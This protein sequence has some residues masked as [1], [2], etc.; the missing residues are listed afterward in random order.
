MLL[1]TESTYLHP[2]AYRLYVLLKHFQVLA[3]RVFVGHWQT[4]VTM[5]IKNIRRR[6]RFAKYSPVRLRGV[7]DDPFVL[8]LLLLSDSVSV[9]DDSDELDELGESPPFPCA[10]ATN[11]IVISSGSCSQAL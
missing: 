6:L 11:A 7:F 4:N 1:P 9:D 3:P 2:Q 10:C 8:A 5:H